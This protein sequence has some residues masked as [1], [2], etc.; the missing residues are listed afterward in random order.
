MK[1]VFNDTIPFQGYIAMTVW[2]Y[3]FV[4]NSAAKRYT[5]IASNH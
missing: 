1:T 5:V 3:I 4:R 2:P